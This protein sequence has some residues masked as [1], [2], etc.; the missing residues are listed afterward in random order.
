MSF[1]K[2]IITKPFL[3]ADADLKDLGQNINLVGYDTFGKSIENTNQY[4]SPRLI[5]WVEPYEISGFKKTLFYTEVNS[6]LM[7]GDRVFIINGNYDNNNLIKKDKYKKGRDGYKVLKVENCK[8]VLDIDYTGIAPQKDDS[9][10]D[11]IKVYYIEN[12][13]S[14]LSA[15]RQVTTRG[16]VFDYK[17]NYG[18]N[19]IV[20]VDSDYPKIDSWG[21]NKGIIGSPGFFVR[22][23]KDV[24]YNISDDLI[25]LGSF[26]VALS[27]KYS[28]NGK[29]LIQDGDFVYNG[30]QFNE[31]FVYK[32]EIGPTGSNWMVDVEYS[33]AIITKANFRN[34]TFNGKFNNGLYGTQ[35]S[36]I[37]WSGKGTW[38]GGTILNSIWKS[39][40]MNSKIDIIKTFK[41]SLDE[42]GYPFQKSY[43]DRND[44]FGFNYVIDSE[45]KRSSVI[46]GNFK[47]TKFRQDSATFSMVENHILSL[48]KKFDNN[49][50]KGY[51]DMCKFENIEVK[52][53]VV[54]NVRA[55]NSK[56]TNVKIVNSYIKKSVVKNSIYIG[57]GVVKILGYDEWNMSEYMNLASGD[58]SSIKDVNQKI[59]K[60]YISKES[61]KRFKSEDVFYIKGL[62]IKDG[63]KRLLNFFDTKFRL[64]SWSEFY[65]DY[66]TDSKFATGV[67][68]YSFHKRGY[69]CAAFLS[70]P[71]ENSYIINSYETEYWYKGKNESVGS[72]HSKYNTTLVGQNPNSG[73]SIDIIVARHDI[74][75]KNIPMDHNSEWES[76]NPKNY[77][78]DSDVLPGTSSLPTYLGDLIDISGAYILDADFES[79]II[80]T[81]DWNSGHH[82]NYNN[83]VVITSVTSSG[84]YSL[85]I[86]YDNNL[87]IA[88]TSEK[89]DNPEKIGVDVLSKGE[90]VFLNS[91]DYDTRGMVATAVI[92]SKGTS[93]STSD[94]NILVNTSILSTTM[95]SYGTNYFTGND[96]KT[97]SS[98]SGT[99]VTIDI[100]ANPIGA[101]TGITYSA[102]LSGGGSYSMTFI[103]TSINGPIATSFST[104]TS[105][106]PSSYVTKIVTDLDGSATGTI[107]ETYSVF[108]PPQTAIATGATGVGVIFVSGQNFSGGGMTV[109][110]TTNT[111]GS[112]KN[113]YINNSGT[114]YLP[115]QIFKVDGGNATFSIKS[116]SNGEIISYAVKNKG[117]DY[118]NGEVLQIQRLFNPNS[119]YNSGITASILI[120]SITASFF[121][122]KGLTLDIT[123]GIGSTDG[124]IVDIKI[125]NPGLYY[126]KG[127]IF[128]IAG[129]NLDAIVRIESITGSLTRLGDTYKIIEKKSGIISLRELGT[130]SLILGL[131]AGGIFYTS[132]AK[133]RWGY[134]SKS[135][136]YKTKIKSGI[137]RRAYIENSIIG[138][139]DYDS[140][141]K[142]FSNLENAKSLLI[143]DTL[144]SN[145]SNI[146]SSAT[147]LYSNIVG[148]SDIW[149]DG[150]VFKSMLNGMTFSKGV[151]RQSIWLDGVFNGG[152]FYDSKSF[153]AKPTKEKPNHLS[154]RV[155][156][157]FLTGA[158]GAGV[159][160]SRYSWQNGVFS[161]GEFYKSDWESGRFK[162]GLFYYSKF[163]NGIIDNGNIGTKD[164]AAIDTQIYNGTINYVT[165]NNAYVYATDTSYNGASSSSITWIDGIFNNG[166]F[167]SN[168]D[169]IIGTTVSN[170]EYPSL[171]ATLPIKDF[172]LTSYTQSVIDGDIILNDLEIACKINLKHPYIGDL[173]INLMA[174]NGK[175]INLKNRYSGG[176][177]DILSETTFTND[178]TKPSLEISTSPHTGDF[179]FANVLNHG[180][181]YKVDGTLLE[182]VEY[183]ESLR[184]I[185][186]VVNY[187]SFPPNVTY[188]GDRY[189]VIATSSDPNWNSSKPTTWNSSV[190]TD[191]VVQRKYDGTWIPTTNANI[192]GD[193]V[194]VKNRNIYLKYITTTTTS[195]SY[196]K[197]TNEKIST[198]ARSYHSN[199]IDSVDLMNDDK[200]INGIWT[201]L[202]M[203]VTGFEAGFVDDFTLSFKYKTDYIIKSF[204]NDAVWHNGIFNGG[205]FID[206]GVWKNGKFNGGKFIST[207][208]YYKSGNYLARNKNKDDYSWQAGEF[209][210]GE[211]GNESSLIN[212]TWFNGVFSDGVFKGKLWNN[213][214]FLY[215]EF[216]GGSTIPVIG[217][218]NRGSSASAFVDQFRNGHY[219]VW[220]GGVVSDKKDSFVTNQKLFTTPTR[221]VNPVISNKKAT[222]T[223]MLW[224]G[225]IFDHPSGS[226]KNSVW[227][228]GLFQMGRFESSSFNPYVK[229][230]SDKLEFLKDDSCIWENGKLV[231]SEFFYSKWNYGH[232]ISGTATGVIWKDGIVN[233]MNA[234]NIFWEKGVWRNGNWNGS[235]FEY[236][237]KVID[238]FAKEIL[239]RGIEWSGTNSCHIWNIFETDADK[240]K[241]IGISNNIDTFSTDNQESSGNNPPTLNDLP[242]FYSNAVGSGTITYT[243]LN[244]GG[245]L[246]QQ[247]GIVWDTNGDPGIMVQSFVASALPGS[248]VSK[249]DNTG[250][251]TIGVINGSPTSSKTITLPIVGSVGIEY[252]VLGYA[253]NTDGKGYNANILKFNFSDI[254]KVE[255]IAPRVNQPGELTDIIAEARYLLDT[256]GYAAPTEVGIVYSLTNADPKIGGVGVIKN[257]GT[258]NAVNSWAIVAGIDAII[259]KSLLSPA[260][261]YYI[262][263]YAINQVGIGYSLVYT[264]KVGIV[265]PTVVIAVP[266]PIQTSTG[267]YV[268]LSGS[269]GYAGGST[270]LKRGFVFWKTSLNISNISN[271]PNTYTSTDYV[272]LYVS[273]GINAFNSS[274]S[275]LLPNTSYRVK[276]FAYSSSV[277]TIFAWD[278]HT[279]VA[280]FTTKLDLPS[281][282][283]L[284]SAP[285]MQSGTSNLNFSTQIILAADATS[286]G[287]TGF[288]EIGFVYTNNYSNYPTPTFVGQN[289]NIGKFFIYSNS[290]GSSP[291]YFAVGLTGLTPG[292]KYYYNAYAK[293]SALTGIANKMID[294]TNFSTFTTAATILITINPGVYEL[295]IPAGNITINNVNSTILEYG[296]IWIPDSESTSSLDWWPGNITNYPNI[297]VGIGDNIPDPLVPTASLTFVPFKLYP[298]NQSSGY[299]LVSRRRKTI[300]FINGATSTNKISNLLPNTKYRAYSY[301]KN[302]ST[303]QMTT[304]NSTYS[305]G[306][307]T[308]VDA[309]TL[310]KNTLGYKNESRISNH[311]KLVGYQSL[312]YPTI[313]TSTSPNQYSWQLPTGN[314]G[315]YETTVVLKTE[316]IHPVNGTD[317]IIEKGFEVSATANFTSPEYCEYGTETF[318]TAPKSV[319]G[320]GGFTMSVPGQ[321]Y[322][323]LN[324]KKYWYRS[325]WINS[326]GTSYG[327]SS[328]FYT[329]PIISGNIVFTD[330]TTGGTLNRTTSVY[331]EATNIFIKN[332]DVPIHSYGIVWSR[333]SIAVGL[334][335]T[336]F[337]ETTYAYLNW[338]WSNFVETTGNRVTNYDNAHSVFLPNI[339]FES[340]YRPYWHAFG[341]TQVTNVFR[342]FDASSINN[343]GIVPN[344]GATWFARLYVRIKA[345][346]DASNNTQ[347]IWH[348]SDEV[349]QWFADPN[350]HIQ[351]GGGNTPVS[352]TWGQVGG[353]TGTNTG[354]GTVGTNNTNSTHTAAGNSGNG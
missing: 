62:K 335:P 212:S 131:T 273:D 228:D 4:A 20:F 29:I 19:N 331:I 79:G 17:F 270:T 32:W 256:V 125:K 236:S 108:G 305:N 351:S 181:Y 170:I 293:N 6:N 47:N 109:N 257:P 50:T 350:S 342:D 59:Y 275:N 233:Y 97:I 163:Y 135:K 43:S 349:S 277:N 87:L 86:D 193:V 56:F 302:D 94:A 300:L 249:Y 215:G 230:Y 189:L 2:A 314:V 309:L 121:D 177:D 332:Y 133:N 308:K 166:V 265:N 154:N 185:P 14:F 201:L 81:S 96:I 27:K 84:M 51:F 148:G 46:N 264:V 200:T 242:V 122:E 88:N 12:K 282:T 285:A 224:L 74:V 164:V 269:I 24:W 303:R 348:Y 209:N 99:G 347:Y 117:E 16:G 119:I 124:K 262:R 55:L 183:Q 225:G 329:R 152:V 316:G 352:P 80:E 98:G 31:G 253:T 336:T 221:A 139:I 326:S 267:Q 260:N 72:T 192:N 301:I 101:V 83:D 210:G 310:V 176:S 38:N 103:T 172:K 333:N 116:V 130:Q 26:S 149:R 240:T 340:Q 42:K 258:S 10:D 85:E 107:G 244:D 39:G 45:L 343:V 319:L 325:T 237:G 322:T 259:S 280:T 184:T 143:T 219:G 250:P 243:I 334:D 8:I 174:P 290:I 330:T 41:T 71:E 220:V 241:L 254:N 159:F 5:N 142:D 137:I 145:N 73:Y 180:V 28:N 167:G 288:M 100:V 217:G 37:E 304:Y 110:Y 255:Y 65:D 15:N 292:Q 315:A 140:T 287:N 232:F 231:D 34:G 205:Q 147:Y 298:P 341:K 111:N 25:Y 168:N 354:A 295:N 157:Y 291:T 67:D 278:T 155:R 173:I 188:E 208:G 61:Y 311:Y 7:V 136:F 306:I 272:K 22:N 206:L 283:N 274:I 49:I 128:T 23:D 203:D 284:N 235:S 229:R 251:N 63:T 245:G 66:A 114:G 281:V 324:G 234:Y 175:I 146:L 165:V 194:Y 345:G 313:G 21:L 161:G 202:V 132:R 182:N 40:V 57:D 279:P 118:I 252:S 44:G 115:G 238:G 218:D 171:F 162:N 263:A 35:E 60:F 214:I 105:T 104:D 296:I 346:E 58:F 222:F 190:F 54:K 120:S 127:E 227:F 112:I 239:N 160:N 307:Y 297:G 69:E 95:S 141:D 216:R 134:I 328:S 106:L 337:A 276:A 339:D 204:K 207:Y 129:G 199:T 123:T 312:I 223:N 52:G 9:L 294:A 197:K 89:I 92:L 1:P 138:N 150:I 113:L 353:G 198:W 91:V 261:T 268:D 153:D 266:N 191:K 53:G 179:T 30:V 211:F 64:T 11:Y 126:S 320:G 196:R 82:I 246:V 48:S 144:F 195:F 213:G 187:G 271:H 299:V 102:P 169:D 33:N 338:N 151:V 286:G 323:F 75:N 76:L 36:K 3:V 18:Q 289:A 248:T 77:N 247:T 70:T 321:L 93:Y 90:I 317:D 226:I 78:Y 186:Q 318:H 344:S 68:Q 327:A 158:V 156:S 178:K 13:E